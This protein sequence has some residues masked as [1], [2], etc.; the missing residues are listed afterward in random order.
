MHRMIKLTVCIYVCAFGVPHGETPWGRLPNISYPQ[1]TP[2]IFKQSRL[3]PNSQGQP[4]YL[5]GLRQCFARRRPAGV[6]ESRCLRRYCC[7]TF[8]EEMRCSHGVQSL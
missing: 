6:L 4:D 2:I 8:Y 3:A 1:I 7:A 5:Q